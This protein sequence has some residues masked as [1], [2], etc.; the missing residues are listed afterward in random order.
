MV[1]ARLCGAKRKSLYDGAILELA[2]AAGRSATQSEARESD[3]S[4]GAKRK[5]CRGQI[6]ARLLSRDLLN[7]MAHSRSQRKRFLGSTVSNASYAN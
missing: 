4:R 2:A 5:I 3:Q 6:F 1:N 7:I